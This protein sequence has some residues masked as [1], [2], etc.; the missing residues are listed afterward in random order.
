MGRSQNVSTI[1]KWLDFSSNKSKDI[2]NIVGPPGM[3]KSALAIYVGNEIITR[4][5]SA[6]YINMAEFPNEQL[7]QVLAAKI[8]SLWNRES[9]LSHISFD[10]LRHWANSLWLN[11]VII[12]D[13]C[14]DCI[15]N[16]LEAF[17][18]AVK[19]LLEFSQRKLKIITSSREI[20]MHL[21]NYATFKVQPLD[22]DSA[23]LL[24]ERKVP[25]LLILTEKKAIADLTGEV[26]LALQIIGALLS[27]G[28]NPPTPS[29]IITNLKNQPISILSP[30][31]LH[32]NMQLNAS[33]SL[34]YDYLDQ[35]TQ[36]I[37]YYLTLFPGSFDKETA[38]E[39][40]S[41]I[42]TD[43][44]HQTLNSLIALSLLEFDDSSGRCSYH[45][46]IKSFFM[47]KEYPL[48]QDNF[49]LA[50]QHFFTKRIQD[51]VNEYHS[52]PRKALVALNHEQSNI[53]YFVE[54]LQNR[55][56]LDLPE[57]YSSFVITYNNDLFQSSYLYL[58]LTSTKL[59]EVTNAILDNIE[60]HIYTHCCRQF[61]VFFKVYINLVVGLCS[62]RLHNDKKSILNECEKRIW[63]VEE[64]KHGPDTTEEYIHFYYHILSYKK[65]AEDDQA[66]KM[67][68]ARL[69]R[70]INKN[71]LNCFVDTS[72]TTCEYH[73]F[74]ASYY[75][76]GDYEKSALFFEKAL[77]K[78]KSSLDCLKYL[79]SLRSCYLKLGNTS[80]RAEVE[81]KLLD[82]FDTVIDQPPSI[83]HKCLSHYYT[84]L[85]ILRLIGET[86][87][88]VAV[89]EKMFNSIKE[90][91]SCELYHNDVMIMLDIIEDLLE[92]KEFER[93]VEL[94]DDILKCI[95][96]SNH[97]QD[98]LRFSLS[99]SKA[100]YLLGK[101]AEAQ[102][103]F[104]GI[105]S[106]LIK[107][108][109]TETYSGEYNDIC[110]YLMKSRNF[111]Y[112][113]ECYYDTMIETFSLNI[114]RT[115][116]IIFVPVYDVY[117]EEDSSPDI[118]Q[119]LPV[120][121]YPPVIELSK[122]T[123][124]SHNDFNEGRLSRAICT[125][126]FHVVI[127]TPSAHFKHFLTSLS[128]YN[129]FRFLANFWSIFCRLLILYFL[130]RA[131]LCFIIIRVNTCYLL[132]CNLFCVLYLFIV[133]QMYF[134]N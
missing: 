25:H 77:V 64:V 66:S 4:G 124:L 61:T 55:P 42:C 28:V 68:Y 88:A 69:L 18:E 62:G 101:L 105:M 46:L 44:V 131:F 79:S 73:H 70:K 110:Y 13:N 100:L 24:L 8:F 14:D 108:N 122:E 59:I 39:V 1:L 6:Y 35:T 29:K 127:D 97:L 123:S 115:T 11:T 99:K 81:G 76:L 16:Q 86:E 22:E 65:E 50:F 12:L 128:N 3:G 74:A 120:N 10:R 19:D 43:D 26:P 57:D 21:E 83:V 5:E 38:V 87:K 111:D 104:Q 75:Y 126:Y 107:N 53:L 96:F 54:L 118:V 67:Y 121:K 109:L 82:L 72:Y 45:R 114:Y 91:R 48:L 37:G 47:A 9:N 49:F 93:V 90:L 32:R 58:K 95:D 89:Y 40:L 103:N 129:V 102:K 15:Q 23:C 34:S 31:G 51:L 112:F 133:T 27:V 117:L 80:K 125:S 119:D 134:D 17:H 78:T 106:Y 113:L 7:K 20:L 36:K 56:L 130:C 33:I 52:N 132:F 30:T 2:V 63:F 84:Y 71:N 85:T 94:V 92:L 60:N 116:Y 41:R 98:Y